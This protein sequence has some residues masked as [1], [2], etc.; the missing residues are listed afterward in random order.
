MKPHVILAGDTN[1]KPTN[2]AMR[3]LEKHF[4]SVFGDE[5]TTTFNMKR[6]TNPGYATAAVDLMYISPDLEVIQK[7]CLDVDVSD[8]LPLVVTLQPKDKENI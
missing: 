1:A 4:V 6:K 7:A 3:N 8:H 2:Q 5:L